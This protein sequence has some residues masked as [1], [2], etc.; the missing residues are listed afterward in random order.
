MLAERGIDTSYETV[1]RWV[2]K[3]GRSY[4]DRIRGRRPRPTDCGHLDEVFLKIGGKTAYLWLAVD[5]EG[6]VLDILVQS[7]R[8]RKAAL[9]LLTWRRVSWAFSLSPIPTSGSLMCSRT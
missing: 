3:F 5:D 4:A 1:R 6:E 8:D 7:K 2:L 9:K